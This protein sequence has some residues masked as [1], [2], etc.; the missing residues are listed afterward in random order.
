MMKGDRF[1]ILRQCTIQTRDRVMLPTCTSPHG[2]LPSVAFRVCKESRQIALHEH[3]LLY[4]ENPELDGFSK[5]EYTIFFKCFSDIF[6]LHIEQQQ[7]RPDFHFLDSNQ[8]FYACLRHLRLDTSWILL[9]R[10]PEARVASI[11]YLLDEA[12]KFSQLES[13]G[14]Y[15]DDHY[16]PVERKTLQDALEDRLEWRLTHVS[17]ELVERIEWP[18]FGGEIGTLPLLV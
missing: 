18:E 17:F 14:L 1:I 7:I 16:R 10:T 9:I 2:Y 3:E 13:L 15:L 5:Q 8:N 11:H 6:Y 12:Q 4:I